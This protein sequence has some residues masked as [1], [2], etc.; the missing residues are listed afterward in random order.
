M[1]VDDFVMSHND[2]TLFCKNKKFIDP[3][4]QLQVQNNPVLRKRRSR[5]KLLNK[6]CIKATM[7]VTKI[8]TLIYHYTIFLGE[9]TFNNVSVI[10]SMLRS[11]KLTLKLQVNLFKRGCGTKE[12]IK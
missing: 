11:F 8:L 2:F 10:N 3:I 7:W 9:V 6:A 4:L 12:A 1:Y 5:N